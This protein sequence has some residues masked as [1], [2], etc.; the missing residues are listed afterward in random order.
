[1]GEA[2]S[3]P[4][5]SRGRLDRCVGVRVP[6]TSWSYMC[7][8]AW[9][10]QCPPEVTRGGRALHKRPHTPPNH[11]YELDK[12]TRDGLVGVGVKARSTWPSW[13]P[14]TLGRPATDPLARRSRAPP[15]S[16]PTF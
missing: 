15:S 9:L 16:G 7:L 13:C 1:M 12:S 5:Y 11:M 10:R 6:H 2:C 14:A 8:P 4:A 3:H